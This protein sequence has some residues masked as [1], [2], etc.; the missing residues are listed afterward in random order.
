M[1]KR[2]NVDKEYQD[3]VNVDLQALKENVQN[4]LS[5]F[6]DPRIELRCLYPSWYLIL[7]IFLRIPFQLQY[8]C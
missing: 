2:K 8:C 6:P 7:I 5:D 1:P 4:F 3:L